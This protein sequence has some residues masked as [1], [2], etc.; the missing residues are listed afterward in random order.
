[1]EF[2][3]LITITQKMVER[4]FLLTA[5]SMQRV[6]HIMFIQLTTEQI[7]TGE[8]YISQIVNLTSKRT[9]N[10]YFSTTLL[11]IKGEVSMPYSPLLS[12]HQQ[13]LHATILS[14]QSLLIS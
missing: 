14:R 4:Y 5:R 1:M 3:D 2:V 8:V 7:K 10:L 12:Q 13:V 6:H 11:Q 9:V